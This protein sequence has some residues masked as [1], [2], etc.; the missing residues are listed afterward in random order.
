MESYAK[1]RELYLSSDDVGSYLANSMPNAAGMSFKLSNMPTT[2]SFAYSFAYFKLAGQNSY[3]PYTLQG[4]E[5]EEAAKYAYTYLTGVVKSQID[6]CKPFLNNPPYSCTTH[7]SKNI[8]EILSLSFSIG[9]A[10]VAIAAGFIK[11]L[12]SYLHSRGHDND[13]GIGTGI[14]ECVIAFISAPWREC[15]TDTKP[16]NKDDKDVEDVEALKK[17]QCDDDNQLVEMIQDIETRPNPTQMK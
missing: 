16:S 8:L 1:C 15:Y 14:L 3:S 17:Q 11:V 7:T 9:S 12:L 6:I 5:A 13:R 2:F 4:A 10:A